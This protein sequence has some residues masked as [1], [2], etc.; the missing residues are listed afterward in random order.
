MV[1]FLAGSSDRWFWSEDALLP[2]AFCVY[3][4]V[5]DG[6]VVPPFDRHPQGDGGLRGCG[7]DAERWRTWVSTVIVAHGRLSVRVHE[8]DRRA[9]RAAL[10]TLAAAVSAP[11][12]LCPGTPE[13]RA[14]LAELWV[15]YQPQGERWKWD[16]TRGPRG[17]RNRLA[18]HEQRRLWE[19]L[20]PFH[21]RLPTISVFLVDYP[22]PVVMAVPPT[23]CLIA[24]GSASV[25]YVRQ[26]VAA[27]EQL[28]A[29]R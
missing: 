4:L 18:P 9:D 14:C 23:T 6:L 5:H 28:A 17:V 8:P 12:A 19:A 11:A 21:G 29:A 22:A 3:A 20:L 15:D 7:L 1:M 10:A 13:L 26:V 16:M 24:P 2:L 25:E 27:A